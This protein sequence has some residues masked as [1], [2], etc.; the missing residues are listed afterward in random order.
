MLWLGAGL[1]AGILLLAAYAFVLRRRAALLPMATAVMAGLSAVRG[2]LMRGFDGALFGS[3]LG[4]ALLLVLG[5]L[6][7]RALTPGSVGGGV[8]E[9]SP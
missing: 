1:A 5:Y 7:C 8:P 6:W 2:G 9:D 3:V 4:A